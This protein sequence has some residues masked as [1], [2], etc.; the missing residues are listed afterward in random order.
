MRV[1]QNAEH[2]PKLADGC[3]PPNLHRQQKTQPTSN[4]PRRQRRRPTAAD[5]MAYRKSPKK[6][7]RN[8]GIEICQNRGPVLTPDNRMFPFG[9]AA[10][11]GL[12]N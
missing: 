11:A 7:N 12:S 4:I 2:P 10:V 8:F 3:L 6:R 1:R 9:I 5:R